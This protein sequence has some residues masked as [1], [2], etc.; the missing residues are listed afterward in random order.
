MWDGPWEHEGKSE[1]QK[2][3]EL[4]DLIQ[5][6]NQWLEESKNMT[7]EQKR[8]RFHI[9]TVEEQKYIGWVSSYKIDEDYTYTTGEGR[10]AIG[11]DI[12]DMS[13]RGRG[14]SY[15]ALCLF[16]QGNGL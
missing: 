7:P 4:E 13:V 1:E 5:T 6:M 12:P 11:I 10:C 2:A 9:E 3:N 14:Y 16:I 8:C 15:Q